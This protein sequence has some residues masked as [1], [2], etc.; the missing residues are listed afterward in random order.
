M[1]RPL[2][3]LPPLLA[4]LSTAA[5]AEDLTPERL[6]EIQRDE[7]KAI[8]KVNAAHGNKKPSEMDN[9]ERRQVAQEQQSATQKVLDQH[10]VTPKAYARSS[11]AMSR[12]EREQVEDAKRQLATKEEQ[13]RLAKEKAEARP[14][15]DRPLVIKRGY[16]DDQPVNV[17]DIDEVMEEE[18]E[19]ANPAASSTGSEPAEAK[20]ASATRANA[21]PKAKA[22]AHRR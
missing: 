18:T 4:L 16:G 7:Q 11:S 5:A 8:E 17:D 12:E 3:V 10:G 2:F 21:K 9:E 19:L 20:S 1:P 13:E 22:K 6:A 15:S 14:K